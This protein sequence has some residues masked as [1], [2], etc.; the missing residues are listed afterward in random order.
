[1]LSQ[2]GKMNDY[3]KWEHGLIEQK[4]TWWGKKIIANT[5]EVLSGKYGEVLKQWS[6]SDGLGDGLQVPHFILFDGKLPTLIKV[7]ES[8]IFS[9]LPSGGSINIQEK[10]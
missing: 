5:E 1:M 10:L 8:G 6:A 7:S 9:K 4:D 3:D 2:N